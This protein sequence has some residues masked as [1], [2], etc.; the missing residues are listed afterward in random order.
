MGGAIRDVDPV[1]DRFKLVPT[2]GHPI[3]ILFD[4]RTRVF[5]NGV[6]ISVLALRPEEHA[7][8]ETTLDGTKIFAVS[9][10]AL[11]HVPNGE[12][13]GQVISYNPS[14]GE[15]KLNTSLSREPVTLRVPPNTP[16]EF[17]GQEAARGSRTEN[18]A[19]VEG[20]LVDVLFKPG[21]KGR[22]IATH[23]AILASPGHA[24][25]FSG[26]LSS[27]D[28]RSGTM[29]IQNSQDNHSYEV[30]FYPAELPVS[31]QLHQGLHVRV[32]ANFNGIHYMADT[33]KI[34]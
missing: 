13:N 3:E 10:H 15:L 17:T 9:I 22:G 28:M 20:D 24:F 29:V 25:V 19:L 6:K 12:C 30:H 1:R 7:S 34:E 33:I 23:I 18:A 32:T 8:V 31:Q 26:E 21:E 11:S 4:A 2:G 16:Q 27:L 5:R 14:T